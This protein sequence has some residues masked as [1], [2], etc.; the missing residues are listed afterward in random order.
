M[1]TTEPDTIPIDAW[2]VTLNET[3]CWILKPEDAPFI[4]VMRGVY[5]FDRSER[6]YCCEMTPSYWLIHLYDL[7]ECQPGTTEDRFQRMAS[8][9]EGLGG[10]SKY[11]HCHEIEAI[12]SKGERFTVCQL[13][14]TNVSYDDVSREDQMESLREHYAANWPL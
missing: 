7:V 2:A 5:V 6:T 13:G 12:I 10:D 8:Y 11:V 4:K 1:L 14:A 3:D 9:Y